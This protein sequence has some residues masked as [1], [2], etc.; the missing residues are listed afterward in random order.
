MERIEERGALPPLLTVGEVA[1]SLRI[2]DA[3]VHRR[4]ADGSLRSVRLGTIVRI[5]VAEVTR[6]LERAET[7]GA[8]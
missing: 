4:I 1:S 2:S 6:L 3:T 8:A 7:R 5:P